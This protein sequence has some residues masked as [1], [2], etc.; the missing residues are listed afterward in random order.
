MTNNVDSDETAYMSRLIWIH[1]VCKS[2]LL[3]S[4]A[5]KELRH[6]LPL[7]LLCSKQRLICSFSCYLLSNQAPVRIPV[8]AIVHALL[9]GVL[10]V[11]LVR[12]IG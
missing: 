6:V 4:A 12:L 2:L 1:A 3:S 8:M 7:N 5:V 10:D 11:K 9:M